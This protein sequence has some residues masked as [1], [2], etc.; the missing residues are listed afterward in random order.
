MKIIVNADD[1][2]INPQVN[3]AVFDL[4]SRGRITSATVLA[5][6]AAV[7]EAAREIP[8][9]PNCSFGAHLNVSEFRPLTT[10][11]GLRPILGEDGCFAGNALRQARITAALRGA[12]F[13]E[14]NAQVERLL[15]LGIP[16]SH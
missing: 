7:K 1:L 5:N 12:M 14:L 11:E 16:V 2:G 4:M 9:H 8:K 13:G 10:D 15:A 6:G 3:A